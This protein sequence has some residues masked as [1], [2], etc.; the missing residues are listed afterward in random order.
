MPPDGVPHYE[1]LSEIYTHEDFEIR[2]EIDFCVALDNFRGENHIDIFCND[3]EIIS[4]YPIP[5]FNLDI[6]SGME[7]VVSFNNYWR[8]FINP[9]NYI[10]D[11]TDS[12]NE[13]D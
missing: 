1:I 7:L 11:F 3:L 5:V 10:P 12:E 6:T 13:S 8:R 2:T 4:R 9:S